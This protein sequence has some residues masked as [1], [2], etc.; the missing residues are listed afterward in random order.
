ML[1]FTKFLALIRIFALN[2]RTNVALLHVYYK[3]RTGIRYKT[4]IRFGIEDFIC[5]NNFY[6]FIC[7]NLNSLLYLYFFFFFSCY[8][9][10][11]EPWSG[12]ELHQYCRIN[13]F[14]VP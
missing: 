13:L 6:M 12:N 9:W 5:N 3:D 2:F 7:N 4:D 14:H 8:G 1:H 11:F 10:T